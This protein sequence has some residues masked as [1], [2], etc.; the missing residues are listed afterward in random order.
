MPCFRAEAQDLQRPAQIRHNLV[1]ATRGERAMVFAKVPTSHVSAVDALVKAGFVPV[2]VSIGFIHSGADVGAAP[3]L[4]VT[5]A[6]AS[7]ADEVAAL[8]ER[9]FTFSRFHLDPRV[10][11]DRA[12]AIKR[13]WAR[14]AC[15]GRSAVTY[16]VRIAGR[17]VGFLAVIA[18][19][20]SDGTYAIIDLIGVD[21]EARGKG[22]GRA[23]SSRFARDWRGKAQWLTVGT[24]AANIPAMQLYESMGYRVSETAFVLH[25]HLENG[26]VLA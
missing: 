3:Q 25:A 18:K 19:S 8:A 10:G 6:L 12:D 20:T 11:K 2:D 1:E 17:I 21:A 9:C 23:M 26:E 14:N 13:E 16:V 15:L 5:T 7:D 24:Q 22:C 4:E